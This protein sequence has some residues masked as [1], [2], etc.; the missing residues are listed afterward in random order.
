[1][2]KQKHDVVINNEDLKYMNFVISNL[3]VRFVKDYIKIEK[4]IQNHMANKISLDEYSKEY[5]NI[6]NESKMQ[7][8]SFSN[9]FKELYIMNL[10]NKKIKN[11]S[12]NLYDNV[13]FDNILF[14]I[15]NS[16]KINMISSN[17][18]NSVIEYDINEVLNKFNNRKVNLLISD[19][20]D[21]QN[22]QYMKYVENKINNYEKGIQKSKKM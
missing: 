3:S 11:K 22:K 15:I 9:N 2:Q 6:I 5:K 8:K 13:T 16:L 14:G 10:I 1:M 18:F 17:V 20:V 4:L 21:I 7:I 19:E 12:I